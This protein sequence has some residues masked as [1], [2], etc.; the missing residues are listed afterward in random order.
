MTPERIEEVQWRLDQELYSQRGQRKCRTC[1][2]VKSIADYDSSGKKRYTSCS[3]CRPKL[4]KDYFEKNPHQQAKRHQGVRDNRNLVS[5]YTQSLKESG[6]ADCKIY[7]PDAMQFDH[8]CHPSEKTVDIAR[9]HSIKGSSENLLIL[10]KEELAKGEYVCVNCHRKRT[11][12]REPNNSR[13]KYLSDPESVSKR[14]HLKYAY[15]LLSQSSCLDCGE[16]DFLVLEFDH[17]RDKK[18]NNISTL[19]RRSN[20]VSLDALKNEIAKCEI[21]CANCHQMRTLARR[22]GEETTEQIPTDAKSGRCECGNRKSR[23]S[24]VCN[25]CHLKNETE[26]TQDR[27]G[28]LETL[29]TRLK[30]SNFTQIGKE[31]GV[32]GNAVKKYIQRRGI[33]PKTLLPLQIDKE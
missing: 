22:I 4:S 30:A 20:R 33:N 2:E 28:D 7:Y 14:I 12:S 19:V 3:I 5:T 18:T 15:D 25:S 26:R 31:L 16:D 21:R 11:Y 27:Y 9:I 1:L 6:C 29:L 24:L 32:S 10:L 17:V 8:T 23:V 13:L